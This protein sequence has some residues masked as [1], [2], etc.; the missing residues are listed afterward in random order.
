MDSSISSNQDSL[1]EQLLGLLVTEGSRDE[2][3]NLLMDGDRYINEL[4][5]RDLVASSNVR[6]VMGRKKGIAT[7]SGKQGVWLDTPLIDIIN[8]EGTIQKYFSHL[9]HRFKKYGIDFSEEPILVY[10]AQHYQNGG[11]Y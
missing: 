3:L 11:D 4:Q 2:V 5:T 1:S 6:Q 9:Y 8:G 10:P 7:P